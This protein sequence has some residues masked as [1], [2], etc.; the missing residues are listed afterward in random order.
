MTVTQAIK[1]GSIELRGV[2]GFIPGVGVT[3]VAIFII[4]A[5]VATQYG[6]TKFLLDQVKNSVISSEQV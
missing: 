4:F 6:L 1:F 3:W 2:F 5:G